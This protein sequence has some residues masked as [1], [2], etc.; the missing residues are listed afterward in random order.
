VVTLAFTNPEYAQRFADRNDGLAF[1][2]PVLSGPLI[3]WP[4]LLVWALVLP[5][6]TVDLGIGF[7]LVD[8]P[9]ILTEGMKVVVWMVGGLVVL[10]ASLRTAHRFLR[11][12]AIP[13]ADV[14]LDHLRLIRLAVPIFLGVSFV[15]ARR[16]LVAGPTV[17]P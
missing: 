5:V 11:G 17:T 16:R 8:D 15:L 1:T 13:E 14:L 6:L 2:R 3:V 10:Q 9:S 7:Y 4:W 12:S